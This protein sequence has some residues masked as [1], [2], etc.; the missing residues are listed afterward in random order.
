M[1][2]EGRTLLFN[3]RASEY[4]SEEDRSDSTLN[5]SGPIPGRSITTAVEKSLIEQT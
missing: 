4:L 3:H 5:K 1:Y 2:T